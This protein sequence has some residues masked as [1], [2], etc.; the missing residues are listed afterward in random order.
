MTPGKTILAAVLYA[1]VALG[2][3]PVF[4]QGSDYAALRDLRRGDMRKLAV[5]DLPEPASQVA[6]E[7]AEGKAVTLARYRGQT[8]LVNFWATWC[9]PCRAEMPSLDALQQELGGADF[10]VVT[11]ATG[12]NPLPA[13]RKFFAEVGVTG[14]P[15]LRD[16]KMALSR[17]MGV[18]GL[19]AS[20]ILNADG[21]EV[22]R[23]TGDADWYSEDA[24]LFLR[25]V[26]A[27]GKPEAA[28]G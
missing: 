22:A 17:D 4:A 1:A 14:L 26:I 20:I 23:M 21:A 15:V 16:P 5:A 9:A 8:V 18:L 28:G 6:F 3:N 12:R 19:P 27:M 25:A 10:Q 7:N 11:I 2:A 13:I 24:L